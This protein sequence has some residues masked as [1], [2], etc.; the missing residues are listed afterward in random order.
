MLKGELLARDRMLPERSTRQPEG[1]LSDHTSQGTPSP[2]RN[3][4]LARPPSLASV[5]I[6]LLPKATG[7]SRRAKW[8]P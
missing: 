3:L 5:S 4:R 1:Q 7:Y 2:G 8:L 6:S